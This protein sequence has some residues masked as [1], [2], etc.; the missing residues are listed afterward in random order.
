MLLDRV[1]ITLRI[2]HNRLDCDIEQLIIACLDDLKRLGIAISNNEEELP[3]LIEQAI[4]LYVMSEYDFLNKGQQY[5][6]CYEKLRD[7]LSMSE[8]Y[9]DGRIY[10]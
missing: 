4:K 9:K 2:S 3:P 5:R 8:Q 1:K 10:V 6:N 7:G